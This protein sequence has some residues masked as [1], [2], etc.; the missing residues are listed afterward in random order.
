MD[1]KIK[2]SCIKF[3]V[4]LSKSATETLGMLREGF[5]EHSLSRTAVFEWHSR[6]KAGECQ[7][8]MTNIQDDQAPAKQQKML[9]KFEN[10]STK[11]V[12]EESMGS[13]T[14]LG[15]VMEFDTSNRKFEHAPHCRKSLFPRLLANDEKQ[16]S[17]NVS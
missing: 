11:T 6:F 16:R 5:G 2:R 12:A 3:F 7:L 8:K 10:S 4:K 14:L 15:S 13:Q 17:V 9:T 1:G